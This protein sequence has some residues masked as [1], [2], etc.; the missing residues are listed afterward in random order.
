[1]GGNP[2]LEEFGKNLETSRFAAL[3][4]QLPPHAQRDC[5]WDL[6]LEPPTFAPCGLLTFETTTPPGEWV[7]HTLTLRRLPDHRS[8]DLDYEGPI[9]GDRGQVKRVLAGTIQWKVFQMD[10][11]VLSIRQTWP[12]DSDANCLFGIA[13]LQEKQGDR[14][15]LEWRPEVEHYENI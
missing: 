9:S 8:I 1:M 12:N 6:L 10:L 11:L 5:H 14:W 3:H 15:E 2:T 7:N 13:K 4:H